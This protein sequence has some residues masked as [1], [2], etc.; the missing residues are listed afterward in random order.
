[1]PPGPSVASRFKELSALLRAADEG[2][3]KPVYLFVGES[4]DTRAAAT[5]LIDVV[6]PEAN[7]SFNLEIYDGRTT[8]LSKILDSLRTPGFFAGAKAI[9]VRETPIFLSGEKRG[10]VTKAMFS[11]LS[12][13]REKDAVEKLLTLV[14][15][16]GWSQQQLIDADWQDLPKTRQKEVFGDVLDAAQLQDVAS[17][18]RAALA[19]D[20]SVT[21]FRDEAMSL[22][23]A[24]E[25]GLPTDA[26]LIFTATAV[27]ARKR[28]VKQLQK[29]GSVVSLAVARERSGSLTRD[30]VDDVVREVVQ[31][32]GKKLS[33][34]AIEQVVRR[35]GPDAAV[36]RSELEKLCLFVGDTPRIEEEDVCSVVTD[37]AASWI[38]DFTGALTT[39]KLGSALGVLRGLFE[40]GEPPL[41][42]LAMIAREVR[43][44]L[45]ARE[46]IDRSIGGRWRAGVPYKTFQSQVL[47]KVDEETRAAFGKAHP[48][49]L[50][51]RF[52]DA[53]R[54]DAGRLRRALERLSMI[55]RT[56]KSSRADARMLIES[57]VIDWCHSFPSAGRGR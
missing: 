2:E 4:A 56:L 18:C 44:L 21:A 13:G 57:F 28:V 42:L 34:A 39:G 9:W 48:F 22:T 40:G 50:Y 51:R 15:L 45:L 19:R 24:V 3:A 10:E 26:I 43:M 29:V 53:A 25:S 20:L 49:V 54:M 8:P 31:P 27:D 32:F 16:V 5:A 41:R 6:V 17:I 7:R 38:F 11:S 30:A 12:A 46:S 1:M 35:S 37:S 33:P 36:L 23:E 55:D 47:P 52:Q 14:A